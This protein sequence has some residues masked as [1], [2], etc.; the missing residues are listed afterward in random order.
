M[1]D[2]TIVTES[3]AELEFIGDSYVEAETANSEK[4][5]N[6]RSSR[7]MFIV[8]YHPCVRAYPVHKPLRSQSEF[9]KPRSIC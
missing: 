4:R 6:Y 9:M 7:K 3:R 2:I 1:H 8:N 5:E